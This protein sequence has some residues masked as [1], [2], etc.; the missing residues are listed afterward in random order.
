MTGDVPRHPPSIAEWEDLLVR[1]EIAPRALRVTL[2]DAPAGDEELRALVSDAA[3]REAARQRTME[4]LQAGG[5]LPGDAS[6]AAPAHPEG[7]TDARALAETFGSLRMR[8]FAMAQRRGVDVWAW[9][10]T[11]A[12]GETLTVYQLFTRMV[13]DDARLLAALRERVR[14]AREAAC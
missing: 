10:G 12:E 4:A 11:D 2:E 8:T 1:L 3:G 9:E 7:R 5:P 6:V 13:R 14:A